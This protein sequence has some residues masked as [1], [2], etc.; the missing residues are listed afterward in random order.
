[1]PHKH[2][3]LL[4]LVPKKLDQLEILLVLV[5]ILERDLGAYGDAG[6]ITTNSKKY[7]KK[8]LELRNIGFYKKSN[9][10]DCRLLGI[11]SRLDA[12]Q[13]IVLNEKLKRLNHLTKKRK[14]ISDIYN[15]KINN[16][17]IKKLT[18]EK[19]SVNHQYVIK[20]KDR[21]KFISY[22]KT[23][24][25]S[26]GIHYPIS[27]NNLKIIKKKF[28]KKKFPNAEIL[29]K[30]CISIPIDPYLKKNEINKIIKV[31]NLY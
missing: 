2:M 3:V 26:Y 25:I 14:N 22:L 23:N 4:K 29:S 15:K 1:M 10:A 5:F 16:P 19:G 18:Y 7:F 24:K 27:I 13:A 12:I 9:K 31:I 30:Q 20:A 6:C 17:K 11:N 8:I 21:K 28:A